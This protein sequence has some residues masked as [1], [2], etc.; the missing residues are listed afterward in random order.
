MALKPVYWTLRAVPRGLVELDDGAVVAPGHD[1]R[2]RRDRPARRDHGEVVGGAGARVVLPEGLGDGDDRL[3]P[4]LVQGGQAAGRGRVGPELL[5]VGVGHVHRVDGGAPGDE[6][7]V[8]DDHP[9]RPGEAAADGVGLPGL[10]VDRV[11]GRGR[12]QRQVGV[13]GQ[14]RVAAGG[15]PARDRPLVGAGLAT[16]LGEGLAQQRHLG[17]DGGV[18]LGQPAGGAAAARPP[19]RRPGRP[20]PGRRPPSRRRRRPAGVGD[21]R[22]V[23]ERLGAPQVLEE[24]G[25]AVEAGRLP[26][27][28]VAE[29]GG[30]ELDVEVERQPERLELAHG[31]AVQ[32]GP[33]TDRVRPSAP[34]SGGSGWSAT[35][36]LTPSA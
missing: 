19:A 2:R 23:G 8:A 25:G 12:V 6:P 4:A 1:Q 14:Q 11:E 3:E 18:A 24:Q 36:A 13:V 17:G 35:Q 5:G 22:G 15:L 29:Q 21:G 16:V 26:G 32:G 10:E 28:L 33:G 9:W 31:D 34:Y 20:R 7:V 30:G 27:L